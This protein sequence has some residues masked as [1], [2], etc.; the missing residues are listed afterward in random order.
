MAK[1]FLPPD[2][3]CEFPA[4]RD[5]LEVSALPFGVERVQDLSKL[6]P[7][8]CVLFSARLIETIWLSARVLSVNET[9]S[10]V[11]IRDLPDGEQI[12]IELPLECVA[13]T[14]RD[15]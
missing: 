2:V 6:S 9:T 1:D 7:G 10:T 13:A 3:T 12:T 15:H 14:H 11:A 4:A 5:A 8:H